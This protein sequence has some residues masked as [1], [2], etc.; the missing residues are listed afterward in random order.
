MATG[1]TNPMM[2]TNNIATI[3]DHT[4]SVEEI[5]GLSTHLDKIQATESLLNQVELLLRTCDNLLSANGYATKDEVV[6]LGQY[7]SEIQD[8]RNQLDLVLKEDLE[9]GFSSLKENQITLQAAVEGLNAKVGP[10]LGEI[11]G[12]A[13]EVAGFSAI[14]SGMSE[15]LTALQEAVAALELANETSTTSADIEKLKG[16]VAKAQA[17]VSDLTTAL[18]AR[19]VENNYLKTALK[20]K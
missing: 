13:T 10:L 2:Y 9:D 12:Y 19:S 17:E 7:T 8:I 5:T 4:H 3:A 16:D 18:T 20:V 6:L 1:T 14:A 11:S 15:A